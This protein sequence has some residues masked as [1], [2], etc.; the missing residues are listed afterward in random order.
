MI[1]LDADFYGL[2]EGPLVQCWNAIGPDLYAAESYGGG[3]LSNSTAV[4]CCIENLDVHGE[5][6]GRAASELVGE[7]ISEHGA[8]AVFDFI[9]DKAQF[10]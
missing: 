5:E 3:E 6:D 10:A 9:T 8:R 2:I 7:A 1:V 4:Q